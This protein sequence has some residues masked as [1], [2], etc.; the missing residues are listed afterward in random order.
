LN[1]YSSTISE[2]STRAAEWHDRLPDEAAQADKRARIFKINQAEVLNAWGILLASDGDIKGARDKYGAALGLNAHLC[3]ARDN[4]AQ[5]EQSAVGRN[6]KA[7]PPGNAL[8]LLDENL[9]CKACAGFYPSLLRR[10]RLKRDT[11][12][13]AGARKDFARVH[14]LLPGNT[15]ALIGTAEIDSANHDF[16]SAIRSLNEA[17]AIQTKS[18]GPAYPD[19]YVQLAEVQ[20]QANDSSGCRESYEK[21]I[22]AAAGAKY[23]VSKRQLRKQEANCEVA[24]LTMEQE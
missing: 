17:I 14:E 6:G 9:S 11:G 15:E 18:G 13:L 10:A 21:A 7:G 24:R 1:V 3:A 5:L 2:L 19:A 16:T 4:W 20:R 22:A 23:S 8:S 12:D